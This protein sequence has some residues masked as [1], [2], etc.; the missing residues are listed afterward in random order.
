MQ[1]MCPAWPAS[2]ENDLVYLTLW[3]PRAR[4]VLSSESKRWWLCHP[5]NDVNDTFPFSAATVCQVFVCLGNT[6]KWKAVKAAPSVC[7]ERRRAA[8]VVTSVSFTDDGTVEPS[9]AASSCASTRRKN[10]AGGLQFIPALFSWYFCVWL[11]QTKASK[12]QRVKGFHS[13]G[14]GGGGA[15]RGSQSQ[16]L[17]PPLRVELD[18]MGAHSPSADGMDKMINQVEVAQPA[19]KPNNR[20]SNC[21]TISGSLWCI[22]QSSA[23]IS[24]RCV[25][26]PP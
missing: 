12:V 22:G 20:P 10:R 21:S 19:G 24:E 23:H 14:D 5:E 15:F 26:C 18:L 1:E 13:D 2:Q 6:H 9:A 25:V 4:S 11:L 7:K 3:E 8:P 17:E 16:S